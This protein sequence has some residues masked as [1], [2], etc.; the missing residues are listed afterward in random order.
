MALHLVITMVTG[1]ALKAYSMT[2]TQNEYQNVGFGLIIISTT[3]VVTLL[4]FYMFF[5]NFKSLK[6]V[7]RKVRSWINNHMC[8]LRSERSKNLSDIEKTLE[9][10]AELSSC[11]CHEKTRNNNLK[12]HDK[13][14]SRYVFE[15]HKLIMHSNGVN[16]QPQGQ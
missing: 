7:N 15:T 14:R 5:A 1:M 3:C 16:I 6:L 8:E 4:S 12:P 9:V 10:P 13:H 2:P 11:T